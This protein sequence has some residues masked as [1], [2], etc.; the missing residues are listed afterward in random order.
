M[1]KAEA[2]TD[3]GAY[4]VGHG[5]TATQATNK[6]IKKIENH[7]GFKYTGDEN[8]EMIFENIHSFG[9]KDSMLKSRRR[10]FGE[11]EDDDQLQARSNRSRSQATELDD[12]D[13]DG[14]FDDLRKEFH[15]FIDS[16]PPKQLQKL[17]DLLSSEE[18]SDKDG[19]EDGSS[20]NNDVDSSGL[21]SAGRSEGASR[22]RGSES[23]AQKYSD[24]FEMFSESQ[25]DLCRRELAKI[26]AIPNKLWA[27]TGSTPSEA[28]EALMRGIR[29]GSIR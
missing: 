13:M 19:L 4:H 18:M 11:D 23:F 21:T 26:E 29:D 16:C 2:T 20:G 7:L 10:R 17:A 8:G 15:K 12:R 27:M 1:F 3:D 5:D 6:L 25:Q 24:T 9:E 14:S 22:G 28:R